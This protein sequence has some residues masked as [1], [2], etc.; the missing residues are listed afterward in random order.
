MV[1]QSALLLILV[2]MLLGVAPALWLGA[3]RAAVQNDDAKLPAEVVKILENA[4]QIEIRSGRVMLPGTRRTAATA[5][6]STIRQALPP[7][8]TSAPT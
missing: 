2:V 5:A 3:A 1:K 7:R 4:D 6:C 8:A